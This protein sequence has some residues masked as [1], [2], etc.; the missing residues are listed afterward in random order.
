MSKARQDDRSTV[1]GAPV[2][3]R[4]GRSA[5]ERKAQRLEDEVIPA[6]VARV[7]ESGSDPALASDRDRAVA[8]LAH[9]TDL[10]RKAVDAEDLPADPNLVELGDTVT[11]G[12]PDGEIERYVIV[13]PSEAPVDRSRISCDSPMSKAILGRRVGEKVEV[14]APVGSFEVGIIAV[15]R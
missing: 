1:D 4:D 3:T 2:L 12:M 6:L 15:E 7:R 9:V 10:L 8:E 5:L 14:A 11:L 13:H